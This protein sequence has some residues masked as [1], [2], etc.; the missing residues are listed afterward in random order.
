MGTPKAKVHEIRDSAELRRFLDSQSPEDALASVRM[1]AI[2]GGIQM[3]P[4]AVAAALRKWIAE[5]DANLIELLIGTV[6]ATTG[7]DYVPRIAVADLQAEADRRRVGL[8]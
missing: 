1:A 5:H 8:N 6:P 4:E 2:N 3:E 7:Y